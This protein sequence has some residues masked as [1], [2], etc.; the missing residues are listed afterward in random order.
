[1]L[2]NWHS[3]TE[4]R[5]GAPNSRNSHIRLR[6]SNTGPRRSL[7]M[8][9]FWSLQTESDEFQ[10]PK[11]HFLTE[12]LINSIT[13]EAKH[14]CP[15]LHKNPFKLQSVLA[16]CLTQSSHTRFKVR[17][18]IVIGVRCQR[19][20]AVGIADLPSSQDQ[21][22]PGSGTRWPHLCG[23]QVSEGSSPKEIPDQSPVFPRRLGQ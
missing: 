8:K 9:R 2:A 17:A 21:E 16:T 11:A 7:R 18:A 14:C 1:M 10:Q 4:H 23:P 6:Q 15:A 20:Q 5:R 12:F 19:Q 22:R 3:S 13:T